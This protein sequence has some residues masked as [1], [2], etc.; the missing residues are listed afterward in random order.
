MEKLYVKR[1]GAWR[2]EATGQPMVTVMRN[3]YQIN[4]Y[5]TKVEIC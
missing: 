2:H 4:G 1:Q 3:F 5:E